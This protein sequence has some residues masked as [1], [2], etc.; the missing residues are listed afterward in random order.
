MEIA[1]EI[2]SA[3]LTLI[4]CGSFLTID[5]SPVKMDVIINEA[6]TVSVMIIFHRESHPAGKSLTRKA[7]EDGTLD[8]WHIYDS[9]VG[10]LSNTIAPVPVIFYDDEGGAP[11]A[12]YLQLHT[13]RLPNGPVKVD[14]AW[15]DGER[16]EGTARY[17]I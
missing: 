3:D 10:E 14:Y 9:V 6:T 5:D 13:Q 12:I 8:E 4:S 7:S 1:I 11:L 2:S 15:W 16:R 17:Q